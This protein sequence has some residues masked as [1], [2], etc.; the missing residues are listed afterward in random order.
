MRRKL[1]LV[2]VFVLALV[3]TGA[4]AQGEQVTLRVTWYDDGNEGAV[5]RGILDQFE[6]NNPDIK[7]ELDTVAYN[8]IL[9]QI[10]Q[11]VQAGE[12]PDLLRL[13]NF[14]GLRGYYLDVTPYLTDAEVY[15]SYFPAGVLNAF[16]LDGE[17]GLFGLPLQTTV[18]GLYANATLFE[19]AGI[20]MPTVDDG[21]DTWIEAATEA[22]AATE[23][24]YAIAFDRAGH[25][26]VGPAISE[27]ASFVNEDGTL[28]ID[29]PGFRLM[30]ER[31]KAWHEAG[32]IPV[33]VWLGAG[34]SYAPAADYF[35][36]GQAVLYMAGSWQINNFASN[37]TDTFDWVAIGNPAGAEA[38]SGMP[39]GAALMA[40]AATEHPEEVARLLEYLAT[41]EV[42]AQFTAET[43]FLP[44]H[45]GL[46]EFEYVTDN[47]DAKAALNV[48]AAEVPKIAEAAYALNFYPKFF[49][50]FNVPTRERLTQYL[51]GELTL[52]EAIER[53][54]QDADTAI[55][56]AS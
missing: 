24:P 20:E 5:L 14:L 8:V 23:T 10:P 50:A 35:I 44:G 42:Y 22:A 19:Q 49:D 26:F 38:A 13:T 7:V 37:I 2:L 18:S 27:G 17:E 33:E 55:A 16:R 46:P 47:E 15:E 32:I 34:G 53:I 30:A 51:A 43:L 41:P 36:S 9:E 40:M 48:F 12:A 28:T 25:R 29:Q 11:Q 52:D 4:F 45:L 54:Q 31:L 1:V 6:A 39:G 21:W 3:S 56:P